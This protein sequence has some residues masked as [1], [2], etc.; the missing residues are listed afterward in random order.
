MIIE[1]TLYSRQSYVSC[2]EVVIVQDT[3]IVV[4]ESFMNAAVS[5]TS[6]KN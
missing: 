5:E 1:I 3:G 6:L 4:V 2:N